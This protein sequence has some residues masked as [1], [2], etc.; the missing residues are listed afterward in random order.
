[1]KYITAENASINPDHVTY[2]TYRPF[3]PAPPENQQD[4]TLRQD[5]RAARLEVHFAGGAQ[6]EFHGSI[7]DTLKAALLA[8]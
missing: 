2:F 1:M 7:A 8:L 3:E 4:E 5:A 6:C